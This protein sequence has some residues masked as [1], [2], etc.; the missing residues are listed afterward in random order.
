[1]GDWDDWGMQV[2]AV[3]RLPPGDSRLHHSYAQMKAWDIDSKVTVDRRMAKEPDN[4]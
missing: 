2:D 1:M 3:D 4:L